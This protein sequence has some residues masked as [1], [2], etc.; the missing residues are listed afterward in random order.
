[1]AI[2]AKQVT[3]TVSQGVYELYTE[4]DAIDL[5]DK[6]IKIKQSIGRYSVD[7]LKRDKVNLQTRMD[8]IDAKIA[9][10]GSIVKA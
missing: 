5:T 1:M 7:S 6:A 8:S 10:I 2:T 4:A 9:A 3:E